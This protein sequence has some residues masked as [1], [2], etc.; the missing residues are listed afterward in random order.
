MSTKPGTIQ[1]AR[2]V[3]GVRGRPDADLGDPVALDHD[4]AVVES[5]RRGVTDAGQR[6]HRVP[7]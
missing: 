5:R 2:Q 6:R 4:Q 3:G 1:A 7:H